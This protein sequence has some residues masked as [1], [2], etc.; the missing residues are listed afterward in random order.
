MTLAIL[1]ALAMVL[2][3]FSFTKHNIMLAMAAMIAWLGGGVFVALG[4]YPALAMSTLAGK[5]VIFAFVLMMFAPL[6]QYISR[7]GKTEI[8]VNKNG[9]MYKI[10]DKTP[11]KTLQTDYERQMADRQQIRSRINHAIEARQRRPRSRRNSR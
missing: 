7:V 9:Q 6:V 5:I 8:S 11:G 2:T 4:Q 3:F 1:V 10:W